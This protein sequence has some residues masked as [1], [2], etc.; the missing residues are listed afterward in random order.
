MKH[1]FFSTAAL[2]LVLAIPVSVSAGLKSDGNWEITRGDTLYSVARELAPGDSAEQARIRKHMV[3]N[4]PDAFTNGNPGMME[5]GK[6]LKVPGTKAKTPDDV[7]G[8]ELSTTPMPVP[9]AKPAPKPKVSSDMSFKERVEAKR[10]AREEAERRAAAEKERQA[11]LTA[12]R[13]RQAQAQAAKKAAAQRAAA[14]ERQRAAQAAKQ[15]A[16]EQAKAKAAAAKKA[17][18]KPVAKPTSPKAAVGNNNNPYVMCASLNSNVRCNY[19]R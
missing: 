13:Q 7:G 15:R 6:T 9:V 8:I 17:A 12:D 2:G 19:W 10:Q 4:S 11:K 1:P 3:K 18:P 16:A 5:V 14:A